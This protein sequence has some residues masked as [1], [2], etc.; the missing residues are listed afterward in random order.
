MIWKSIDPTHISSPP[1]A[2]QNKAGLT[3]LRILCYWVSQTSAKRKNRIEKLN[4][5]RGT[6]LFFYFSKKSVRQRHKYGFFS[7]ISNVN[8]YFCQVH[9]IP[10]CFPHPGMFSLA[11]LPNPFR[12]Y[13]RS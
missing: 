3:F 6:C 9:W 4:G 2:L 10:C 5:I 1:N 8:A 11:L 13:G 12:S 7:N